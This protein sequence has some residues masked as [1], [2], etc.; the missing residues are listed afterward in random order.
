MGAILWTFRLLFFYVYVQNC[1]PYK[2]N[3]SKAV[4]VNRDYANKNV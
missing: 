2:Y 3:P 4:Q 1:F